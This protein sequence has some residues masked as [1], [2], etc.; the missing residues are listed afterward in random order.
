VRRAGGDALG[1]FDGVGA[2]AVCDGV[3]VGGRDG[4]SEVFATGSSDAE[5]CADESSPAVGRCGAGVGAGAVR[6]S[7]FSSCDRACRDRAAGAA[8]G[9]RTGNSP[10]LTTSD[11]VT[12][13]RYPMSGTVTAIAARRTQRWRRPEGSTKTGPE[14]PAS[15]WLS[16]GT[17][18]FLKADIVG[19][20][21]S[22]MPVTG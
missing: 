2:T 13:A 22:A 9:T 3:P 16:S 14:V 19:Q 12:N 15:G 17:S 18:D 10:G 5:A 20:Y 11:T 21:A 1:G 6:C 8:P 7:V 4:S